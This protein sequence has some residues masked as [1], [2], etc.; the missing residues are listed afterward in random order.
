MMACLKCRHLM[1]AVQA[2]VPLQN[3]SCVLLIPSHFQ[4]CGQHHS[5]QRAVK[6]LHG[7]GTDCDEAVAV[8]PSIV[9]PRIVIILWQN[10]LE[11]ENSFSGMILH[12]F[13]NMFQ[14]RFTLNTINYQQL[15]NL[16]IKPWPVCG[17]FVSTL[18]QCTLNNLNIGITFLLKYSTCTS[19]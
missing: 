1:Y 4:V 2:S 18:V 19:L 8:I 3:S 12:S 6:E 17:L 10:T 7:P 5:W 13:Q 9:Q 16:V 14:I 15:L 11:G